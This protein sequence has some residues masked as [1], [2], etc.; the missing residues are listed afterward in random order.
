MNEEQR[1]AA[2]AVGFGVA[3]CAACCAGPIVAAVGTGALGPIGA[4]VAVIAGG[5]TL[6]WKRTRGSTVGGEATGS[7]ALEA[8][9]PR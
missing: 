7:S 3:A 5:A 6:L 8:D 4:G 9:D 1:A 2:G